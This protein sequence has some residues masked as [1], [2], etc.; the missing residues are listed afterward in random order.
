MIQFILDRKNCR[1][2]VIAGI[3]AFIVLPQEVYAEPLATLQQ[4]IEKTVTSNPEVQARY[5]NFTSAEYETLVAKGGLMPQ[6]DLTANY[7]E[8]ER[9]GPTLG[10]NNIPE[11]RTA[12]V[13]RQMLFDGFITSNDVKRLNHT[14]RVR[15]YELQSTMQK[16]ALE[17]TRAYLDIQ[18]SRELTGYA[19]DN[20]ISHKQFYDRIEERVSAGVGRRVD[21]EQASGRL[22]LAEANLLTEATNL[23]DSIATY[24]RLVGE[25]PPDTLPAIDMTTLD[26]AK[27]AIEALEVAYKG[28]PD[29]LAAIEN[30]VATEQE[31]KSRRGSYM[32]R[33]DL[34][35]T[36]VLS[37]SSDGRES[38]Q[39]ADVLEL[40]LNFNLFNGLAD[41]AAINQSA[42]K[43]ISTQDLR[44]K[45]CIDTRQTVVIAYNDIQ[46]LTEQLTYRNQHQLSI[47]KAREAYR[48]QFEIGQRTL[49]D[50][51][52][53]ENE[54]FQ[55]RRAYT[56]TQY[57]LQIAYAR[58]YAGQ[59]ELLT[60]LGVARAGLP[61]FGRAEYFDRQNICEAVS[62][63]M[64]NIDKKA[65]LA[66]ARPLSDSIM[67]PKAVPAL[68][69]SKPLSQESMSLSQESVLTG[70]L[71]GWAKA[72][73]ERNLDVYLSYY[74]E[75]FTPSYGLSKADWIK[76][77]TQ[78]INTPKDVKLDLK[79]IKITING[80]KATVQMEAPQSAMADFDQSYSNSLGYNDLVR[81]ELEFELIEGTWQIVRESVVDCVS[82]PCEWK[83]KPVAP[84]NPDI[85]TVSDTL[86]AWKNAWENKD[87][88]TYIAIYS[89]NFIPTK[90]ED[91]ED[92][93]QDRKNKLESAGA[94]KINLKDISIDTQSDRAAI[95][96]FRQIYRS[97]KALLETN[98]ELHMENV[99][100]HWLIKQE[101]V[102]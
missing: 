56:N 40:T 32:P 90:F 46:T 63:V 58:T 70:R 52:D 16:V 18:R 99:G 80:D 17:A 2:F 21:L 22:A 59:G 6:V 71:N 102:L 65:L 39:A 83:V 82:G 76:Q 9:V 15:Y 88:D 94:I 64:L 25:L 101:L 47:E 95:V 30:I 72:W 1:N 11:S 3:L 75:K 79:N 27:T 31:V 55:A 45:A 20:Y 33:L 29:L 34:Q 24:Q 28:N 89:A 62:P 51:L 91:K 68:P 38:T 8:Q 4:I 86:N 84:V 100:G 85:S 14:S 12:L 74:A 93:K 87:Y 43:L 69:V 53:T 97:S 48:K 81:K 50:L 77:R 7:R 54:Y 98:K 73:Q 42:Q 67:L 19:Q 57:N 36:K 61:D 78:R 41:R 44:D 5:H 37:T 13:L 66:N 35:A 10:N 92:W 23:H 60:K 49:L 96:R 26:I